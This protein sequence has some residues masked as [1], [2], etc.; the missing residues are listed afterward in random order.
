LHRVVGADFPQHD[1][2][3]HREIGHARGL[4]E[5]ELEGAGGGVALQC[6]DADFV[7]VG[8]RDL[9]WSDHGFDWVG[10]L[11]G[12]LGADFAAGQTNCQG[13]GC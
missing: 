5:F 10:W 11:R 2:L 13:E 12:C 9:P 6:N 7:A 3:H 1:V 8:V 4:I